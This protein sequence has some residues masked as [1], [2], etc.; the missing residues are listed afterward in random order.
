MIGLYSYYPTINAAQCVEWS[1]H[2]QNLVSAWRI[3]ATKMFRM[4][5]GASRVLNIGMWFHQVAALLTALRER[6]E[7]GSAD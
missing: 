5:R 7:H 2:S 6:N 3:H 4:M 1:L